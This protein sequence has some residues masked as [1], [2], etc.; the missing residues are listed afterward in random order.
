MKAHS[1]ALLM[2]RCL[3]ISAFSPAVSS[4]V[5]SERFFCKR[6]ASFSSSLPLLLCSVPSVHL[7]GP[8]SISGAQFL[9]RGSRHPPGSLPLLPL[10]PVA[11]FLLTG[12]F[13]QAKLWEAPALDGHSKEGPV[14]SITLHPQLPSPRKAKNTAGILASRLWGDIDVRWE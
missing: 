13:P 10:D 4:L 3:L 2:S 8:L 11:P 1:S 14:C 12:D 9:L 7:F 6:F 5:L